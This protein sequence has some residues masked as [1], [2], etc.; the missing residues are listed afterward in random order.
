MSFSIYHLKH[1]E[2]PRLI[3]R[4]VKLGDEYA[5]SEAIQATL[6]DLQRWMP[7]S[8]D[9]SFATT[10]AFVKKAYKAWSMQDSDDY[11]MVVEYKQD[12]KIICATGFN[13]QSQPDKGLYEIGYCNPP[14]AIG[15][16]IAARFTCTMLK[17][18]FGQSVQLTSAG[19]GASGTMRTG[20]VIP[21][22]CNLFEIYT[23]D[24]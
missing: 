17:E 19:G 15:G 14:N 9:P 8:K 1:I 3:I 10:E 18:G 2:T 20:S 11:P 16:G 12:N 22:Y 13:E 23:C 5:I 21:G 24:N 4:P 6:E 7:W